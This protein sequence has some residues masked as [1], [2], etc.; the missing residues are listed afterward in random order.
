MAASKVPPRLYHQVLTMLSYGQHPW[1]TRGPQG[2]LTVTTGRCAEACGT[3][4]ER[5]RQSL[6]K[7]VDLGILA[8][9]TWQRHYFVAQLIPPQGA[10]WVVGPPSP[11]KADE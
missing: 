11:T 10:G 9:I 8:S 7:L 2:H 6:Y 4:A 1:I 5:L 3:N